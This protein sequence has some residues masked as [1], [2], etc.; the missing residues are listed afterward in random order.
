MAWTAAT[1]RLIRFGLQR[2][3]RKI[4]HHHDVR[5][6]LPDVR[7]QPPHRLIQ[8]RVAEAETARGRLR[9][10]GIGVAQHP[11]LS[12]TEDPQR[13]GSLAARRVLSAHLP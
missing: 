11:R 9:R 7:D 2:A 8:R 12:G 6:E 1:V 5:A 3:L 13:I 10:T 4:H